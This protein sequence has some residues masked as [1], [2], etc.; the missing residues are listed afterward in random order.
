MKIFDD[1]FS[2][3][4]AFWKEKKQSILSES[5]ILV[6]GMGGLGCVVA[7]ILVRAG[8]GKLIIIDKKKI[9][10][11][12][13]NR[14]ILYTIDN[15]NQYKVEAA[16]RKLS[17]IHGL[18]TIIPLN[19]SIQA[20]NFYKILTQYQFDGIADCLDNYESRFALEKLLLSDTFLVHGGVQEDYGQITT[21]TRESI[22]LNDIY[23]GMENA[24]NFISI[25][26][27]IVFCIGS[28]MA[29]EILKN[30]WGE[31][32][33]INQLLVVELSDFSFSKIK[34]SPLL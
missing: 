8:I 22:R 18:T 7:E 33:L 26:P 14:Q 13:L 34:L 32:A 23:R 28:L 16:C 1:I 29:D 20:K 30:L 6:A 3:N 11:P 5:S 9:D 31:P 27:Q 4:V 2:R 24:K 17:S 19:I 21:I 10:K 12:D 15:L 25:S